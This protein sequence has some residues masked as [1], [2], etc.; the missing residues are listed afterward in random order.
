MGDVWRSAEAYEA[1]VGRWSRPVARQFV[2]ALG[3]APGSTWID[4]GCGSGA[5]TSAIVELSSPSLVLALD[6]SFEFVQQIRG[7]SSTAPV[8]FVAG[9][10]GRLPFARAG[11][12]AAVSGLVLNFVPDP[13]LAVRAMLRSVRAG[14]VVATYLWDYREG[15]QSIRLFWDAA[16]AVS[17]DASELDEAKRF[18]LCQPDA[19]EALFRAAG[20]SDVQ[21]S[22]ITVPMRFRDFDELWTPFLGGQGPAPTYLMSL[23]DDERQAVRD[24]LRRRVTTEADGSIPL[25][26]RAWVVRAASVA[27]S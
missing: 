9:D 10:A 11:A 12:D 17:P 7:R 22:S 27:G 5:L 14:G 26:A 2:S 4:V 24:Q 8:R 15:M 18:P 1:Y 20:A 25:T 16:I 23:S 3:V 21:V 19:L 6:R 13:E